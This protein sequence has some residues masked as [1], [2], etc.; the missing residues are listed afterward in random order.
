MELSLPSLTRPWRGYH[1]GTDVSDSVSQVLQQVLWPPFLAPLL[2]QISPD[3]LWKLAGAN[4]LR[5][6]P[7]PWPAL[8]TCFANHGAS[9]S[10]M[11][12]SQHCQDNGALFLC[13]RSLAESQME[14]VIHPLKVLKDTKNLQYLLGTWLL[15][16]T[17]W[18]EWT[19]WLLFRLSLCQRLFWW[20][21]LSF[22]FLIHA[23]A[24][25]RSH[26]LRSMVFGV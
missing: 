12:F 1:S 18:S 22:L 16:W 10:K 5:L 26:E 6:T 2:W 4:S 9:I 21:Y 7:L 15:H 11:F 14:N 17:P 20:L 13:L 19:C 8:L 23:E 3:S 24:H 25:Y